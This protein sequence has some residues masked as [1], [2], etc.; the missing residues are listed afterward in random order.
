MGDDRRSSKKDDRDRKKSSRH[1]RSR[2]RSKDRKEERRR[3]SKS[4]RNRSRER[5]RR[6]KSRSRSRDDKKFRKDE[7]KSS[8]QSA[9]LDPKKKEQDDIEEQMRIRREKLAKW[10][11][12]KALADSGNAGAA[13]DGAEP[14]V[15]PTDTSAMDAEQTQP[16]EKENRDDAPS[17]S[18]VKKQES[19]EDDYFADEQEQEAMETETHVQ[20]TKKANVEEKKMVEE[21]ED[22][23]LES[24]MKGVNTE[25][26][27]LEE[28]DRKR[29]SNTVDMDSLKQMVG[30]RRVGDS[31]LGIR[32][33]AEGL[34]MRMEVEDSIPVADDEGN[35][36]E[37]EFD[38]K[39]WLEAKNQSK[40]LRPVDHSKMTYPPFRKNFNVIPA[41]IACMTG[42]RCEN[43]K[44]FREMSRICLEL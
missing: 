10:R 13:A 26:K 2:S 24:F 19:T 12:E 37:K 30:G 16:G 39:E 15:D 22:D 4:P 18:Q 42:V 9:P 28:V 38:I 41:E 23:P 5:R 40:N 11:A 20:E 32:S 31:G 35:V 43:F 14:N 33:K 3:R 36:G 6:S 44:K 27:K 29:M 34:G 17:I 1:S 21:E 25:V 7:D 8:K